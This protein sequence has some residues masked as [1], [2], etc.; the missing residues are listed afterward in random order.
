[1]KKFSKSKKGQFYILISLI[2]IVYLLSISAPQPYVRPQSST[3]KQIYDNYML[4]SSQVLNSG[5]FEDNLSI[6]FKNY[7][8]SFMDY[9]RT[10]DPGFTM[11][12]VLKNQDETIIGNRLNEQINVTVNSAT[13]IIQRNGYLVINSSPNITIIDEGRRYNFAFTKDLEIKAIFK[14]VSADEKV[15]HVEE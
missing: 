9:G 7:S 5:L 8:D 11:A 14:K 10:K 1:M 2:L 15:I 12:Y 3:F 6:R 13:F 4:E